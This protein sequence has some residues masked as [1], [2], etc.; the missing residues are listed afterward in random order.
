MAPLAA[1]YS[2][3]P[4]SFRYSK[5]AAIIAVKQMVTG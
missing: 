3:R 5:T 1:R 4:A 2:V